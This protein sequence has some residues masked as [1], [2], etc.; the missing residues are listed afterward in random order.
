[1]WPLIGSL[2]FTDSFTSVGILAAL[3]RLATFSK[4]CMK[5]GG[6]IGGWILGTVGG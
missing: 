4:Q 5:L 1:M 3:G 2:F 6:K